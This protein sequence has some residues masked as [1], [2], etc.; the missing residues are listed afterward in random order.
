[1]NLH[2]WVTSRVYKEGEGECRTAYILCVTAVR[3]VHDLCSDIHVS[4]GHPNSL[5]LQPWL[6]TC[7]CISSLVP[8]PSHV[9]NVENVGWPGNVGCWERGMLNV[10]CWERGC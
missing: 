9:L 2:A 6:A 10:G 5:T 3:M 1:M 7:A 8:R 4:G